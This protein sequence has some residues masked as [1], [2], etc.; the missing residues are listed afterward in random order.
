LRTQKLVAV[1]GA[2]V[3]VI[4]VLLLIRKLVGRR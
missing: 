3:G 2:A 1:G 4:A